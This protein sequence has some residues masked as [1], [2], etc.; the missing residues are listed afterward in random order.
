VSHPDPECEGLCRLLIGSEDVVEVAGH[1]LRIGRDRAA[2]YRSADSSSFN[3]DTF[4]E[5]YQAVRAIL[6]SGPRDEQLTRAQS[7]AIADLLRSPPG[8]PLVVRAHAV[9]CAI[10]DMR[11]DLFPGRFNDRGVIELSDSDVYPV[12]EPDYSELEWRGLVSRPSSLPRGPD[13]TLHL[14][15]ARSWVKD[16]E[17]IF[18][19]RAAD[20]L[21]DLSSAPVR[22]ATC[23]PNATVADLIPPEPDEHARFFGLGPADSQKQT[24]VALQLLHIAVA[25]AA[26]VVVFPE[27]SVNEDVL[28]ALEDAFLEERLPKLLVAGSRHT[29]D[30]GG[31]PRNEAIAWVRGYPEAIRHHKIRPYRYESDGSVYVEG[32]YLEPRPRLTVH[33][34]GSRS[35][36][37]VI[38][39]DLLD[40]KLVNLLTEL[41]VHLVLVPAMSPKMSSFAGAAGQIVWQTQAF[42]AIANNPAVWGTT[43]ENDAD[44]VA[45][46]DSS[47]GRSQGTPAKSRPAATAI[48]GEPFENRL[49]I[50]YFPPEGLSPPGVFLLDPQNEATPIWSA[51]S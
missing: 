15:L 27:L 28:A 18:D 49:G 3:R 34:T 31:F 23:H 42:V 38:C 12:G 1:L 32:I 35:I 4:V 13:E 6:A 39:R 24:D 10:D 20:A 22:I 16:F 11:F 26:D 48:F 50:A 46:P 40:G 2:E 45:E 47:G 43:I 44:E 30:K 29:I 51:F 36:C 41:G 17:I 8:V 7:E 37:L 19:F 21:D 25:Q 14:R 5:I 33:S 9:A